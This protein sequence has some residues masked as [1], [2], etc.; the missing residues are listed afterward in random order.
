M[1]P[2]QIV[3]HGVVQC[4]E[5]RKLFPQMTVLK[6]LMLGAYVHRRDKAGN[7]QRLDE[8]FELFPILKA[9]RDDPAG[10]LSGEFLNLRAARQRAEN[11]AIRQSLAVANGNLSKAA[12]LLGI[13]RPTL[14]DLLA[15]NDIPMPERAVED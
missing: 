13:T 2:S 10:S 6:N 12:E 4:P 9:K 11:E 5:G 8:V 3:E 1:R 14:Y 7:R 15:K